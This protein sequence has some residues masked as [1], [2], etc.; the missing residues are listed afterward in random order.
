LRQLENASVIALA[1]SMRIVLRNR[2]GPEATGCK[3]VSGMDKG[4][5]THRQSKALALNAS[6][7]ALAR[8]FFVALSL[9]SNVP[10]EL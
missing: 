8:C 5:Y 1:C 2:L 4:G 7:A 10:L 3:P 9:N 6:I